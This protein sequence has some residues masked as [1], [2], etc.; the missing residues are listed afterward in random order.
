MK[1]NFGDYILI[2]HELDSKLSIQVES[3]LG[4]VDMEVENSEAEDFPNAVH[5]FM[6]ESSSTPKA[7]GLKKYS[8]GEYTFILGINNSG[9]LFLFYSVELYVSKKVISGEPALT[10]SF[11][12]EPTAN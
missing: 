6:K 11:L 9:A 3:G 12:K 10:L 2:V 4:H 5:Y 8:F 7:M 1:V